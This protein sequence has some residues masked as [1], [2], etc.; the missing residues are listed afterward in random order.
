MLICHPKCT[1]AE[2]KAKIAQREHVSPDLI[3]LRENRPDVADDSVD[4]MM[5][6]AIGRSGEF[7]VALRKT[8]RIQGRDDD[9]TNNPQCETIVLRFVIPARHPWER[10]VKRQWRGLKSEYIYS[11]FRQFRHND[12]DRPQFSY[13]GTIITNDKPLGAFHI[14]NDTLLEFLYVPT[15]DDDANAD[16]AGD[17]KV[18]AF[19]DTRDQ[20]LRAF[21]DRHGADRVGD[22]NRIRQ[23][24]ICNF[25]A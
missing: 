16:D 15:H 8:P 2:L 6:E 17:E 21:R 25:F 18:N 14:P 20:A 12:G 9:P 1:H 24:C 22:A 19:G 10:E 4:K 23:T 5:D 7:E 3:Y 13:N 11:L